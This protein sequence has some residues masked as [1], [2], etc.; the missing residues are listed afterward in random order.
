MKRRGRR[1]G[2]RLFPVCR[3]FQGLALTLG[4][5]LVG[6]ALYVYS[7]HRIKTLA[8]VGAMLQTLSLPM[9]EDERCRRVNATHLQCLPNVFFIGA[10]KCGTTS[11]TEY[12]ARQHGVH[13][14]R[15]RIHPTDRHREVHRFDR[16][17]YHRSIRALEL[18]EEWASSPVV[19]SAD[20]AVIHYTPHYLYAPTV[21]FDLR[22][23]FPPS[24]A[25]R[26]KFIVILRNPTRRALSSYWFQNSHI[27]HPRDQGSYEELSALCESEFARRR[28]FDACMGRDRSNG[29]STDPASASTRRTLRRRLEHCFGS[30]LRTTSLGGLHVDKGVYADQLERWF[31]NFP[32]ENF[33]ITSLEQWKRDAVGEF[34]RLLRFIGVPPPTTAT[35]LSLAANDSLARLVRPNSLQSEAPRDLLQSLDTFFQPHAQRLDRLLNPAPLLD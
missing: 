8:D 7:F 32:R 34:S 30:S 23:L 9:L 11:I 33:F 13:F 29:S 5:L 16:N 26:L 17:T 1:Y 22:D 2:G 12:L 28:G 3:A 20:E 4:G 14:V 10:S 6:G 31:A 24:L 18:L 15:R 21:P 25:L 27:F 35:G 19:R